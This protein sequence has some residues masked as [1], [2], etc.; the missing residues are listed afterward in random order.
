MTI[1]KVSLIIKPSADKAGAISLNNIVILKENPCCLTA[2]CCIFVAYSFLCYQC[3]RREAG[4]G[5]Y[6]KEETMNYGTR[7]GV[8][9]AYVTATC[10]RST[11]TTCTQTFAA[12]RSIVARRDFVNATY[13]RLRHD[14]ATSLF[15]YQ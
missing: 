7:T 2:I 3:V 14:S 6:S 15:M 13:M 8:F 5:E 10:R 11:D 1:L 9:E 4:E 12:T